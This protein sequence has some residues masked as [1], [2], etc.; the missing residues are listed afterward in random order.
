MRVSRE[1]FLGKLEQVRWGVATRELTEQSASY[2]FSGNKIATFNDEVFC[3]V[4]YKSGIEGA[5][6]GQ[7][8]LDLLSKMSEKEI[9]VEVKEKELLIRGKNNRAGVAMDHEIAPRFTEIESPD[10]WTPIGE[11]FSSAIDIVQS[12]ASREDSNFNLTCIHIHPD[13]LESCDNF[14]LIRYPLKTAIKER[15]LV[16]KEAVR[17]IVGLGMSEI[18][19]GKAWLHF[20]STSGLRLSCRKWIDDYND[21][22]DIL[23]FDGAKIILPPGLH[24]A[25]EKAEIFSSEN[26]AD[27]QVRVE[28]K[29]GG[30]R[31]KG[32][33]V[34]G[35]YEER[36]KIDYEGDV[37]SF[38]ISPRLLVEITKRTNECEVGPGRLKVDAEKFVYVAC[39]GA[40]DDQI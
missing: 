30:L 37:I 6:H 14:Q 27:D 35:W 24:E 7:P 39:L 33:G 13:F 9:E 38:L 28:I 10:K 17:Q 11:E 2:V 31:L 15:C 36:R 5:V 32:Q 4:E 19:E 22:S 34:H 3:E 23:N 40:V 21:L 1:E 16:R 8:L 18:A 12:C 20:H 26:P 29:P 25:V